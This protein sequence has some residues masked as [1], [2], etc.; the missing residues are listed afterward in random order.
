MTVQGISLEEF[1]SMP[2][3]AREFSLLKV[4]GWPETKNGIR[5]FFLQEGVR[6]IPRKGRGG[7]FVY[8]FQNLPEH[9]QTEVMCHFIRQGKEKRAQESVQ[10]AIPEKGIDALLY[11]EAPAFNRKQ[12]DK[13]LSLYQAFGHLKGDEL[14]KAL[15]WKASYS[16]CKAVF[17]AYEESGIVGLLGQYG[18]NRHLSSVPD[19]A[20]VFWKSLVMQEGEPSFEYSWKLTAG[21]FM[22]SKSELASFPTCDAFLRRLRAEFTES[23]IFFSRCG[24]AKWKQKFGFKIERD[25]S[26][27]EANSTWV[28][29]HA[30]IDV[31]VFS[32]KSKAKREKVLAPWCTSCRDYKTGKHLSWFLQEG[33]PNSDHF[34]QVFRQGAIRYGLPETVLLDN[35]KDFRSRDLTGGRS[36]KGKEESP[37]E[38][39]KV[40]NTMALLGVKVRFATPYEPQVK[41]IERDLV[42][43]TEN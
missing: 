30:Q 26:K 28:F 6:S 21:K 36:K 27:V 16:R 25:A 4:T 41:P 34:L 18:G 10:E 40:R 29:D 32:P 43:T 39:E 35:G 5:K 17:K 31:L 8:P 1:T 3:T 24:E 38:W 19:D 22:K 42:M 37:V 23:Q 14:K 11:A 33:S 13:Y 9:R 7:G 20:F 15:S 2:R 12:A